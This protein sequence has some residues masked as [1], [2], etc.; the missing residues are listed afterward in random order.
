MLTKSYTL[1]RIGD[2]LAVSGAIER[3]IG[4]VKSYREAPI[5]FRR[6]AIELDFL[7]QVCNQVFTLQPTAPDEQAH[8]ERIRA[9]S[10]QCLG[11]L[12]S[13]EEKMRSYHNTFGIQA[14]YTSTTSTSWT[15][16]KWRV[17]KPK[18]AQRLHW[19]AIA[20]HEVDELRAILTSE[21]LAIN[22]ILTMN[23]W[24]VPHNV[25]YV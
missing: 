6:L 13:F 12:R 5:H 20:R 4:E 17:R 23:N 24:W 8:I 18:A 19:S 9:I 22:V 10:M 16:V 2:I 21:I 14:G 11:P 3:I 7:G 1:C 25:V 15:V